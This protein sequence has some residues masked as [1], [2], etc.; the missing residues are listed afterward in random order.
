[1]SVTFTCMD[2]PRDKVPCDI[3][4]MERESCEQFGEEIPWNGKGGCCTPWCDGTHMQ[5][6][7]PEP[8]FGNGNARNVLRLLGLD[9]DEL[10]G[11]C[12]AATMLRAIMKARNSDRSSAVEAPFE[13]EPGHAGTAVVVDDNGM[14]RIERRGPRVVSFGNTDEQTMRRLGNLTELAQYASEH[15]FEIS[16]G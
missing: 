3:C 16:W 1:M 2:A 12:D 11:S 10:Y 7:S 15:G 14:Q 13:L 4:R 5:T 9:T 8:N 6:Q